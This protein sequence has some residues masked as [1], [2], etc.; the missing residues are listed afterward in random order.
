MKIN[1]TLI[2]LFLTISNGFCQSIEDLMMGTKKLY[3]ANYTMDFEAIALL[4]YPKIEEIIGKEALLEKLDLRHQNEEFRLRLQLEM[5]PFQFGPIQK[6]EEESFCV[7]TFRNPIRYFFEKKLSP[8][9]AVEKTTWLKE[10]NNTKDVIF[11]P[12]RNSFNVKKMST[13]L[14]IFDETTNNQWK[15]FNL[16]DPN[17]KQIF[18]TIFNESVKKELGL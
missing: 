6:I 13:Y 5:V 17:Q 15:F 10:I 8:E 1:L 12:K 7:V 2:V 14:A 3:Q 11:E 18:D 4:S 9:K 16:D